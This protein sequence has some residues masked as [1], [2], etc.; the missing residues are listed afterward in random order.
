MF[1]EVDLDVDHCLET[2]RIS[3]MCSADT[4]L[5]TFFWNT[6]YADRPLP[7]S[8]SNRKCVDWEGLESWADARKVPL[9]P[10]LLRTTGEAD[11]IHL[12]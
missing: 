4:S 6:T 5:Y 2:L 3:V 8:S 7:K 12:K 11:R 9:N 1:D 10:V